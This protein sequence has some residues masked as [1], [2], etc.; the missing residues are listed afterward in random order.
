MISAEVKAGYDRE[1]RPEYAERKRVLR[2]GWYA[3]EKAATLRRRSDRTKWGITVLPNLRFRAKKAGLPCTVTADDL[4]VPE[5]CPVLGFPLVLT[6]GE[7]QGP[8]KS[9]NSPSVDRFDNSKGYVPG[10]VRVISLRANMLKSNATLE[11]LRAVIRYM[12]GQ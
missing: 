2:K 9:F 12:E 1:R 7:Y 3:T 4:V 5:C 11:E 10:N 8:R 6:A